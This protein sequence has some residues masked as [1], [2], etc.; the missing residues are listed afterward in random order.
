LKSVE[1]NGDKVT[2]IFQCENSVRKKRK[3]AGERE[4]EEEREQY[5]AVEACVWDWLT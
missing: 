4:G 2:L 3:R 5:F 1:R